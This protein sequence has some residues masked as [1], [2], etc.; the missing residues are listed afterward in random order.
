MLWQ[1]G[2]G[3]LHKLRR[4]F[5]AFDH[6][7]TNPCLHFCYSKFSIF[8]TTYPPLVANVICKGSLIGAMHIFIKLNDRQSRSI[9]G[10][11]VLK[12][13]GY[14]SLSLMISKILQT[15]VSILLS[16]FLEIYSCIFVVFWRFTTFF[17]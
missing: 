8:L 14:L 13:N 3:S 15:L 17:L 4:H 11:N 5:L 10:Q 12:R 16:G 2:L 9:K 7:P 1:A 6:V